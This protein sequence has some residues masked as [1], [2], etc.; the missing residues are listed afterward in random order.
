M[1]LTRSVAESRA[2]WAP[3]RP[4]VCPAHSSTPRLSSGNY[5]GLQVVLQFPGILGNVSPCFT[6]VGLYLENWGMS[7]VS[8][9][10]CELL[11]GANHFSVLWGCWY[12]CGWL[13]E[14]PVLGVLCFPLPAPK[15]VLLLSHRRNWRMCR[16]VF[17]M[18]CRWCTET[19][20]G[21]KRVL[22]VQMKIS[23]IDLR[24]AFTI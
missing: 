15:G 12:C 21:A 1:V 19:A 22:S 5:S 11:P 13:L 23:S 14:L 17:R 8:L 24:S 10:A 4:V 7:K 16:R 3:D 20:S 6:Q 18:C 9:G 2:Q